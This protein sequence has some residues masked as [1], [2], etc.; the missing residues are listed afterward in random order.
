MLYNILHCINFLII[1]INVSVKCILKIYF[2]FLF[3]LYKTNF[4]QNVS[5][6]L[7]NN[8]EFYKENWF[9]KIDIY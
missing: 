3:I 1:R 2:G 5:Y 9:E 7:E 4:I 8:E 6:L